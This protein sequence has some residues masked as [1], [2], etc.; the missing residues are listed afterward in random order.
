[1]VSW[2]SGSDDDLLAFSR[3]ASLPQCPSLRRDLPINRGSVLSL[4]SVCSRLPL[5]PAAAILRRLPL[6]LRPAASGWL[7]SGY[8]CPPKLSPPP[9]HFDFSKICRHDTRGTMLAARG[10]IAIYIET[11]QNSQFENHLHR[12]PQ[13][14]SR[15]SHDLP[16]TY[17]SDRA[18]FHLLSA[19]QHAPISS[20]QT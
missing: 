9:V 14:L 10:Q 3:A 7:P 16:R 8:A 19:L 12:S 15:L 5:R 18:R 13:R 4:P 2:E 1:M 11:I 6:R 17:R 20:S